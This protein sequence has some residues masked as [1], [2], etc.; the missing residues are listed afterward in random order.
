MKELNKRATTIL[1]RF[2]DKIGDD[3]EMELTAP[4]HK[5]VR[6]QK[7]LRVNTKVGPGYLFNIGEVTDKDKLKYSFMMQFLV[8]DNRAEPEGKVIAYPVLTR[9]DIND[10][11]E[12]AC[13]IKHQM[14]EK[15]IP[16]YQSEQG[17]KA[18]QWLGELQTAGY[19]R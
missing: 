16:T 14:I 19:L 4:D 1:T 6:L 18:F 10:V 13:L 12:T 11:T 5:P 3:T 17:R 9:D 2:I 7:G 8:V 15:Y